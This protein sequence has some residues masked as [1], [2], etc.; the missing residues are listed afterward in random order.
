MLAGVPAV[1]SMKNNLVPLVIATLFGQYCQSPTLGVID[2][3][4]AADGRAC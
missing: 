2:R 1:S 3:Y 4:A